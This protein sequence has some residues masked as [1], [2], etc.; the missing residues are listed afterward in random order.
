MSGAT[1][2]AVPLS[3]SKR[4]GNPPLRYAV[5]AAA[6]RWRCWDGEMAVFDTWTGSTHWLSHAAAEVLRALLEQPEALDAVRLTQALL[7]GDD[8]AAPLDEDVHALQ[9]VLQGLVRLGLVHEDAAP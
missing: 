9:S 6:L 3:E 4:P 8:G 7:P 1:A 2:A 5:P